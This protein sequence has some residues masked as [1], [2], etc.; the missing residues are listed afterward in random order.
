MRKAIINAFLMYKLTNMQ[1]RLLDI[2]KFPN[3]SKETKLAKKKNCET[4]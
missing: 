1:M 4:H 2:V 3:I